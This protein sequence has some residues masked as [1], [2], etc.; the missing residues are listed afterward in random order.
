MLN[1]IDENGNRIRPSKGKL[2]FCQLCQEKVRAYCG[3]INIDHWRHIEK[4]KCDSW[5]DGETE[6]HREWKNQ[7]PSDWQEVIIE[8]NFERH[9]A[10]I[11]TPKNL[12]LELQN[13]SISS[14]TIRIRESFYGNMIWLV[15]ANNFKDNF[16]PLSVV[17]SKLRSLEDR[18]RSINYYEPEESYDFKKALE[19]LDKIELRLR[20]LNNKISYKQRKLDDIDNLLKNFGKTVDEFIGSKNF[21]SSI[22]NDFETKAKI[23]LIELDVLSK[24]LIEELDKNTEILLKIEQLESCEIENYKNYKFV[25]VKIVNSSSFSKCAI[26]E[27]E[28][29]K[30]FFP[31]IIEFKSEFEFDR[32][33]KNSKYRLMINPSEKI[34]K[35]Q[36]EIA[37]LQ[38]KIQKTS[39]DKSTIEEQ[40]SVSLKIYLDDN[41]TQLIMRLDKLDNK[42][43]KLERKITSKKISLDLIKIRD[44]E[45]REKELIS[46]DKQK[47]KDRYE[48]MRKFKG[49]Y[50]YNWK[51]KRKTWDFAEKKIYL[52]LNDDI[53][54]II[55]G[56]TLKKHTRTDFID[57]VKNLRTS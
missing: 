56:N 16:K 15:N 31:N 54:E 11:K 34:N 6:W 51:Y 3:E 21:Y 37:E 47:K 53:F 46:I 26:I 44:A 49:W 1:A 29:E 10:D 52:D 24:T 27:I 36:N 9:I 18:Y 40:I 45:E 20:Q 12:V 5:N 23:K 2:G 4:N 17:T 30:S 42:M 8:K 19:K 55:N 43:L 39:T 7:F 41:K 33:A 48:I 13:S 32:Y 25:P 28:T 22:M 14:A 50:N 57:H 35:T 38:N